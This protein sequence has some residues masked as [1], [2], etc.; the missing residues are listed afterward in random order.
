MVLNLNSFLILQIAIWTSLQRRCHK[1]FWL[2]RGTKWGEVKAKE[3]QP[4]LQL[5]RRHNLHHFQP[6]ASQSLILSWWMEHWF[7]IVD[8]YLQWYFTWR[9]MLLFL[10][11]MI[12]F[13]HLF[14]NH[15]HHLFLVLFTCVPLL[16]FTLIYCPPVYPGQSSHMGWFPKGVLWLPLSSSGSY[17]FK[18]QFPSPFHHNTDTNFRYFN[19]DV[20][21][22]R[23]W[24]FQVVV[25][26]WGALTF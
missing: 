18:N 16:Y 14:L 11:N 1:K 10:P 26:A 22:F 21:T 8:W 13:I 23:L 4:P 25:C 3:A 17:N 6:R 15:L 19:R 20:S 5:L 7:Y 9:W 2:I 24:L 12:T